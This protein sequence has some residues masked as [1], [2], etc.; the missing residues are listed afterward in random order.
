[1]LEPQCSLLANTSLVVRNRTDPNLLSDKTLSL[2]TDLLQCS[3]SWGLI[4]WG[5]LFL[6][7]YL[8]IY[9][10]HSSY[11]RH[12]KISRVHQQSNSLNEIVA[13]DFPY[14]FLSELHF[15]P[16]LHAYSEYTKDQV[17][18]ERRTDES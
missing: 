14:I 15:V 10:S 11:S 2:V 12:S 3:F 5:G 18:C 7:V 1:M 13:A 9:L 17:E 16:Y 6:F 8:I 4:L